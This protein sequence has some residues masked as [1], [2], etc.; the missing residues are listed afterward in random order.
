MAIRA[1]AVHGGGI[2]PL[3]DE[4]NEG[5]RQAALKG[6]EILK[7]G[8]SALDAVVEAIRI[9]ED[10]PIFNSGTGSWPNLAGDVEMDAVLV[11]GRTMRAG[12]VACIRA[13]K[14]PILVARK[15]LE[16][17]DHFLLV[18][19]GAVKFARK[20]GFPEYDP[21]TEKRR[22]EWRKI[23]KAVKEGRETEYSKYWKKISKFAP[24]DTVGAV[25]LDSEGNIAAGT[26]SGGFPLKLPG[27]VGDVPI[28]NFSTIA[29]NRL[30]GVSLTGHGETVM[31]HALARKIYEK[32]ANLEPQSA[33]EMAILEVLK[34]EKYDVLLGGVVVDKYGNVGAARTVDKMPHAYVSDTTGGQV[35]L[36]FGPIIKLEG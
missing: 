1:I 8:G 19:D 9:M 29:N 4:F 15:V 34:F 3:T 23:V 17:T 22:E 27:R 7:N 28:I 31:K 11:D 2:N 25:A 35:K 18:G 14:N 24:A 12:A 32:S 20:M 5:V 33:I 10:N 21:L 13:V 16:E 36:N 6:Y 30:C 26:S